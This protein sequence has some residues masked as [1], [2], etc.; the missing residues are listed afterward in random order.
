MEIDNLT[1]GVSL[2]RRECRQEINSFKYARFALSVSPH[3]QDNLFRDVNVQAGKLAKIR[4]GKAFEVHR[5]LYAVPGAR[6]SPPRTAEPAHRV[7]LTLFPILF[8]PA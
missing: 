3:Q 4:K 1:I 5:T 6:I 2:E 8:H 7:K